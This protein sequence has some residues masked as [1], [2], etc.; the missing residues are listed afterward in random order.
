MQTPFHNICFGFR[1]YK[2]CDKLSDFTIVNN[3]NAYDVVTEGFHSKV[4]DPKFF[5]YLFRLLKHALN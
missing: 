1:E 5:S 3:F 2:H 4:A